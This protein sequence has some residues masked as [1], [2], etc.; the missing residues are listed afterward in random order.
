MK[1]KLQLLDSIGGTHFGPYEDV[2][3]FIG[4]AKESSHIFLPPELGVQSEHAKLTLHENQ[5]M[6]SSDGHQ[7]K[8]YLFRNDTQ[9]AIVVEAPIE[10]FTGDS[11]VLGRPDGPKFI[12][13]II[14]EE[15]L[16]AICKQCSQHAFQDE[17]ACPHCGFYPVNEEFFTPIEE[18]SSTSALYG[19]P[20]TDVL[21]YREQLYRSRESETVNRHRLRI[22]Y[23][24]ILAFALLLAF[25]LIF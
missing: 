12:L 1:Y 8:I 2:D 19:A 4:S 15:R 13:Q 10:I 22:F 14:N 25:Y 3:I 24:G 16:L 9:L 21:E 23:F 6:L 18:M 5:L 7:A 17:G 20:P 11:F